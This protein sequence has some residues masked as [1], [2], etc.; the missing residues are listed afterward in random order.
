MK[1]RAMRPGDLDQLSALWA[2]ETMALPVTGA[3]PKSKLLDIH[4][5]LSVVALQED[6]LIGAIVCV[7]EGSSGYRHTLVT[8]PSA[9]T[10]GLAEMLLGKV[11]AKMA[12]Q[13]IHRFRVVKADKGA[14]SAIWQDL[15]WIAPD[16]DRHVANPP[17]GEDTRKPVK[18]AGNTG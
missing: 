3:S 1:V 13:G 11:L 7:R 9:T 18:Q 16:R 14:T 2:A 6:T 4:P 15:R 12:S 17:E 10:T 5:A 8:D